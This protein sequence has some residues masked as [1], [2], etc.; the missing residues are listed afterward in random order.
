MDVVEEVQMQMKMQIQVRFRGLDC[1]GLA[2]RPCLPPGTFSPRQSIQINPFNSDIARRALTIH[3]Q[4]NQL[5]SHC[6][7]PASRRRRNNFTRRLRAA[8][9]S[10]LS[11][12]QRRWR[13]FSSSMK[14]GFLG[15]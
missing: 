3:K 4:D 9:A 13:L 6:L 14:L 1:L 10:L 8:A 5:K 7:L 15:A 11:T 12:S 2:S